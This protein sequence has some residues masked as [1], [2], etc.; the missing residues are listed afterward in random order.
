MSN[1]VMYDR[2]ALNDLLPRTFQRVE[3]KIRTVVGA[4]LSDQIQRKDAK[5]LVKHFIWEEFDLFIEAFANAEL[6]MKS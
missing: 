1:R 5:A 4:A 3:K 2:E 6:E